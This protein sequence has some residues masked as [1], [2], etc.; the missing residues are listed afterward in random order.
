MNISEQYRE[1]LVSCI[2][3]SGT[4]QKDH[5]IKYDNQGVFNHILQFKVNT[6]ESFE[7]PIYNRLGCEAKV[8]KYLDKY[9]NN[10]NFISNVNILQPLPVNSQI[11]SFK[12]AAPFI[13]RG[14]TLN[15]PYCGVMKSVIQDNIYYIT[16]GIILDKDFNILL[17]GTITY[18]KNISIYNKFKVSRS[19]FYV[20][21][22]VFIN[23]D[24]PIEKHIVN[25]LLPT[26]YSNGSIPYIIAHNGIENSRVVPI[27]VEI[28]DLDYLIISPSAPSFDED[29]NT[30]INKFLLTNLNTFE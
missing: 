13:N 4:A 25:K 27:N 28:K 5:K 17:I 18:N 12:S 22:K 19:N 30:N 23:I 1:N 26:Y 24:K 11:L 3:N 8:L 15:Y 29:I 16:R 7:L 21:P 2:K 6:K 9:D 20:S 14:F 10:E